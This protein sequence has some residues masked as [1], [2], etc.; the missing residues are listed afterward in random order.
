[1]ALFSFSKALKYLEVSQTIQI[2]AGIPVPGNQK[3]SSF[4]PSVISFGEGVN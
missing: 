2:T 4:N 1:M 3:D